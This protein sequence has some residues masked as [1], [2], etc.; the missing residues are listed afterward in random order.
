MEIFV[1]LTM[2]RKLKDIVVLPIK[3]LPVLP[4]SEPLPRRR[5][6]QAVAPATPSP[7]A[8]SPSGS[9]MWKRV[10]HGWWGP[11]R[12]VSDVTRSFSVRE[13][14]CYSP[15]DAERILAAIESAYGD[16]EPFDKAVQDLLDAA[17]PL[18]LTSPAPREGSRS[19]FLEMFKG[20]PGRS[21]ASPRDASSPAARASRV[22]SFH[23]PMLLEACFA[24]LLGL[25]SRSAH[26]VAACVK[27]MGGRRA[28]P[29]STNRAGGVMDGDLQ[30]DGGGARPDN[31]ALGGGEPER[32]SASRVLV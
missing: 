4:W 20:L 24:T 6:P 21:A 31:S 25:L 26:R 13:A 15:H 27:W 18:P 12:A 29:P 9:P 22:S 14:R 8:R 16:L 19:S 11:T 10:R 23:P 1:F 17:E 7:V 3:D 28:E 32:R 2:G 5:V 30:M